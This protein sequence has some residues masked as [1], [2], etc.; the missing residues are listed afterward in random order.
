MWKT[1]Q[2]QEMKK[3][4]L[5]DNGLKN[6]HDNSVKFDKRQITQ[7]TILSTIIKKRKKK[8]MLIVMITSML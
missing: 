5:I 8:E 1:D 7:I 3:E 6:A 4:N 2:R